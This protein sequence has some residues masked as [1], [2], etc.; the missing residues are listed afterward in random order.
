MNQK[1]QILVRDTI[2]TPTDKGSKCENFGN[3]LCR[4]GY[5]CIDG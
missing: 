2:S 4:C 5:C 1:Q 3:Q